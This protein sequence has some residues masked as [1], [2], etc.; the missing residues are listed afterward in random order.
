MYNI[1]RFSFSNHFVDFVFTVFDSLKSLSLISHRRTYYACVY[2][3]RRRAVEIVILIVQFFI[4]PLQ[5][6]F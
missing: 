2:H 6:V 1:K 3:K 5:T 4:T